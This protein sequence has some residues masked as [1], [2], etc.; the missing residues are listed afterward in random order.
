MPGPPGALQNRLIK[1]IRA[2]VQAILIIELNIHMKEHVLRGFALILVF[3]SYFAWRLNM[4]GLELF[5]IPFAVLAAVALGLII[6]MFCREPRD[7]KKRN[8]DRMAFIAIL[9]LFLAA[10]LIRIIFLSWVPYLLY[11]NP[12]TWNWVL[13]TSLGFIYQNPNDRL[14]RRMTS[15]GRRGFLPRKR[16]KRNSK[17]KWRLS[18]KAMTRTCVLSARHARRRYH[19]ITLTGTTKCVMTASTKPIFQRSDM[20]IGLLRFYPIPIYL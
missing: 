6:K 9:V 12:P 5:L 10:V 15:F 16:V 18:I 13:L 4:I 14:W 19:H 8:Q 1:M 20:N 7:D 17:V 11:R 2:G 3:F